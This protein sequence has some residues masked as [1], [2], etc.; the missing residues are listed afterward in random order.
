MN[1]RCVI[2]IAA[3]LLIGGCAVEERVIYNRPM[4]G[5]LP[6]AQ[7]NQPVTMPKGYQN[8]VLKPREQVD[9]NNPDKKLVTAGNGRQL[10]VNIYNALAKQDRATFV[11]QILSQQARDSMSQLGKDP[12]SAFDELYE[13]SDELVELFNRIPMGEYTPGIYMEKVGAGVFR[14]KLYGPT[15]RGLYFTGFDM[16][17]ENSSWR[18]VRMLID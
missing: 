11:D 12:G 13:K 17:L 2:L 15:A 18:L 3:T 10:M 8:I 16:Q 1:V 7:V 9:P 4:F 5:A 14:V 6:N